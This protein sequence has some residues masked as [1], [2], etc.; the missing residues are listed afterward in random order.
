MSNKVLVTKEFHKRALLAI[1]KNKRHEALNDDFVE[2]LR[3]AWMSYMENCLTDEDF[4][5][6]TD[7][8]DEFK[9]ELGL[10][11]FDKV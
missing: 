10:D 4:E 9:K 1:E 6:F 3:M 5:K 11:K 8:C 7:Y 2:A